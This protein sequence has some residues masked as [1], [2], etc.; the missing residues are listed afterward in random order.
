MTAHTSIA[1][2]ILPTHECKG[3]VPLKQDLITLYLI[4]S[5]SYQNI[6][7]YVISSVK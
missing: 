7:C 3:L 2:R 1:L 5:L 4:G 6:T